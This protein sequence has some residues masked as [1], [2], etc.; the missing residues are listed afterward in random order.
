MTRKFGAFGLALL[1]VSSVSLPAQ[2][3][4]AGKAVRFQGAPQ[5]TQQE[6]LTAA[7][8]KPDQRLAPVEI[9]A[10]GKLLNDTGVF[11]EVRFSSDAKTITFT[12]TP[13]APLYP[14][15][16]ENVPLTPGKD[17]DAKLH[18]RF[19]L[20][21]GQLPAM[22]PMVDGVCRVLEE[23]LA[24]EGAKATVK[25]TLTSGLGK[26]KATAMN[27]EVAPAVHIGQIQY[28]GVSPA[29]QAK[30]SLLAGGQ[31]GNGFDT[32]NSASG[33][34]RVFE[35]LYQDEGYAAVQVD[36]A[37]AVTLAASAQSID[38]PYTV[39]IKE[40][41]VY[42]LG[43]IDYP[44][45]ALISR[46]E[47]EKI[48]AKNPKGAGRPF[49]LFLL[50]VGDAYHAKGYLDCAVVPHPSFNEGAHIVN[51][52]LEITPGTQYRF[53][54]VKF[55]GAPEAMA[56]RLK[57]AWKMTPGDVFDQS[58]VSGFAVLAQKKDKTLV[59]WMSGVLT[60]Y[61]VKPDAET[62]QV[63]CSFHFAAKPQ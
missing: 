10:H 36:V 11:K 29:M 7:G 42:K 9:K 53:G 33:L 59:R 34:K 17:L 20:Y 31:T 52:S 5:Y 54:S 1:L 43:T 35:D 21:H 58:F 18:E 19:P 45:G 23:M 47:V 60:T 50:A 37:Q 25:A 8:L 4:A 24:A 63:N 28:A 38:V 40:G 57:A 15:H 49:D 14:M 22:G 62:H 61:D 46:G 3:K 12:L 13:I 41:G 44:A 6:L 32:E 48:V 30:V 26:Q 55:E 51:Y 27:F 16:F 39:T 2:K 56:A